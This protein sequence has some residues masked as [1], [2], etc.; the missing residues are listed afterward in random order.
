MLFIFF[1]SH[2]DMDFQYN[3]FRKENQV[4]DGHTKEEADISTNTA[5][6]AGKLTNQVFF[7]RIE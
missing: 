1:L 4:K 2:V 6:K 5:K 3:P 7:P